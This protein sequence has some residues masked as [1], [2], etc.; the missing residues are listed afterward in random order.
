MKTS[1]YLKPGVWIRKFR[2][3]VARILLRCA[4]PLRNSVNVDGFNIKFWTTSFLE[5]FL[6]AEESY[7]RDEVTMYWIRNFIKPDDVVYDV[8]ANVGAYSLLIGKML[9][10]G[11]GIVY[12]I[13]PESN[14]YSAL[15]RN[16]ILNQLADKVVAYACAFGDA[17][18]ASK[19]YL[20]S[21]IVGSSNHAVDKPENDG[22]NFIPPHVQGVLVESLDNFVAY[23]GIRFPNHIKIDVDG[24]EKTIVSNMEST[25]A[26]NRLITIMI[27][28][29]MKEGQSE[30]DRIL[31]Q[32]GFREV[33]RE[34]MGEQMNSSYYNLL[35]VRS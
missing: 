5:Y 22:K 7:V 28:V 12:A 8:G 13:E 6:R 32:H 30:I 34:E 17:R 24:E 29:E 31:T 26:D 2:L 33:K 10:G 15:N 1:K 20:S 21:G 3:V 23:D 14:N 25:L 4:I 11:N 35:Y 19:L 9:Q 27:E 18:R 16:I